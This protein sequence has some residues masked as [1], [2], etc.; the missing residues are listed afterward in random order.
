MLNIEMSAKK[1]N[2]DDTEKTG[3]VRGKEDQ[4]TPGKKS[5]IVQCFATQ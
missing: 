5:P 2:L 4:K 1:E 3:V